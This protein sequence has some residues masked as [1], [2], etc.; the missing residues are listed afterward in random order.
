[1]VDPLGVREEVGYVHTILAEGS[2]A[3]RQLAV[4][5]KTRSLEAVVDHLVAETRI[6]L[7]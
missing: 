1:V 4:Y 2:S 7:D 5:E 6:G 3:D